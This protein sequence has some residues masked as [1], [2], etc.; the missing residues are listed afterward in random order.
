MIH[1]PPCHVV[2]IFGEIRSLRFILL[3]YVNA[4][5]FLYLYSNCQSETKFVSL[6]RTNVDSVSTF[7]KL[8]TSY[9][10]QLVACKVNYKIGSQIFVPFIVVSEIQLQV[11]EV[12][13]NEKL[14]A[15]CLFELSGDKTQP[16]LKN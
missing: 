10:L 15:A 6:C 16:N 9:L 8:T 4:I 7:L 12:D 3:H 13:N 2:Y 5:V 11:S 1:T 14:R